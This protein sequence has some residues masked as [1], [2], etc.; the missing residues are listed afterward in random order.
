MA[1]YFGLTAHCRHR[2]RRWVPLSMIL[3]HRP[4]EIDAVLMRPGRWTLHSYPVW[5]A[6]GHRQGRFADILLVEREIV[7]G[8]LREPEQDVEG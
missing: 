1:A 6:A 5:A 7:G 4:Q 2:L 3:S 8:E